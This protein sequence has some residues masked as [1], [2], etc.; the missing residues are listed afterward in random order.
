MLSQ[1]QRLRLTTI[2]CIVTVC[3]ISVLSEAAG[4]RPAAASA[5]TAAVVTLTNAERGMRGRARLR[6]NPRLMRAAQL[7]AEQMAHAGRM[8]HLLPDAAYPRAEDRLA[9][10]GYRWQTCG[11]N[12]ALGQRSAAEVVNGWMRSRGHRRNILSPDFTELGV[13]YA[14]DRAGQPYYVQVFGSPSS[15]KTA[16]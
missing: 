11:E 1:R 7:Q 16:S 2:I 5:V 8:A 9:E 4:S 10:A 6:T 13:G 14:I 12:V 15:S 3:S